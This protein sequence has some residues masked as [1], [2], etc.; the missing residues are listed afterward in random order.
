MEQLSAIYSF[1]NDTYIGYINLLII[2]LDLIHIRIPFIGIFIGNLFI[3]A[4]PFSRLLRTYYLE[5]ILSI[6]NFLYTFFV[7]SIIT[8]ITQDWTETD[9]I[10]IIVLIFIFSVFKV[11]GREKI[12][13]RTIQH[14]LDKF[15]D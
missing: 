1:I 15:R 11:S 12:R 3:Y 13:G 9:S 10:L 14:E 2:G 6:P 5:T 4:Y 8:F 7:S